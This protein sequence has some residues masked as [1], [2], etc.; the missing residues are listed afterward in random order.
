MKGRKVYCE[1]IIYDPG[2]QIVLENDEMFKRICR[3]AGRIHYRN[4]LLGRILGPQM[5]SWLIFQ[6]L[7]A[8]ITFGKL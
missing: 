8:K 1:K 2:E 6:K 3:I 4:S 7:E 5:V